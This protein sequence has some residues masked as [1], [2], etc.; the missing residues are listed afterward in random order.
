ME[1]GSNGKFDNRM[2]SLNKEQINKRTTTKVIIKEGKNEKI[3][4]NGQNPK[5]TELVK[6]IDFQ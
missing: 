5:F 6:A 4:R 2:W 1:N 3:Y